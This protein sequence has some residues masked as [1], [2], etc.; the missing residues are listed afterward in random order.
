MQERKPIWPVSV[1]KEWGSPPAQPYSV[2]ARFKF[3]NSR[4]GNVIFV[5]DIPE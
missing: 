1:V 4:S 5:A 2:Q 3:G